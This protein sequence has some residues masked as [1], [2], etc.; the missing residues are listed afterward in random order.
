MKLTNLLVAIA[1]TAIMTACQPAT[2]GGEPA[3]A[4]AAPTEGGVIEAI[5]TRTS[6]RAYTADTVAAADVEILLRA[7]M[8]APT[9]RDSRPWAFVVVTDTAIISQ[10]D[11]QGFKAPVAIVACGN[12]EKMLEGEGRD[13]WVQDV[14][15]AVENL[16]VQA[17]AMGL[18]AVW[19]GVYPIADRVKGVKEILNMPENLIPLA[20]VYAGKPAA[21]PKIKDKWDTA[22]IYYNKF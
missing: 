3:A 13:Y 5:A 10:L 9:A 8:A 12:T 17:N 2:D 6:V 15:A 1:A 19:T 11:R 18:G 20:I 7:A 21:E 4:T 14:S 16:L 22:N